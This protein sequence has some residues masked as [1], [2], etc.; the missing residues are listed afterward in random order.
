[1]GKT[2]ELSCSCGYKKTVMLGGGLLA[3]N[4]GYVRGLFPDELAEVDTTIK[5]GAARMFIC[6]QRLAYCPT[7]KEIL[8]TSFLRYTVDG[9]E[10][11]AVKE[12]PTCA[13]A[14]QLRDEPTDC[15]KCGAQMQSRDSGLWD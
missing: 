5:T 7:C 3:I 12:C 13:E 11:T 4:E 6:E 2:V 10:K 9:K 14:L 8:D 15:P 1:M